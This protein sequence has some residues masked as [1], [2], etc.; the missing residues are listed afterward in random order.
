MNAELIVL[1][2]DFNLL[3]LLRECKYIFIL[4]K[5]FFKLPL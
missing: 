4:L 3:F 2:Q 1:L 5:I